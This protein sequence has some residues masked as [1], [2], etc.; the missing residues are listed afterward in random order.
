MDNLKFAC[1]VN[2]SKSTDTGETTDEHTLTVY[3]YNRL[4]IKYAMCITDCNK[5]QYPKVFLLP[6][7]CIDV[8]IEQVKT[9]ILQY[10]Y[11]K[12]LDVVNVTLDVYGSCSI[13]LTLSK[14][15]S[16]TPG[17]EARVSRLEIALQSLIDYEIIEQHIY[18][19]WSTY[20]E[21]QNLPTYKYFTACDNIRSMYKE[22]PV[23]HLGQIDG[24]YYQLMNEKYD[25]DVNVN[26]LVKRQFDYRWHH[27]NT[28]KCNT[29]DQF[30]NTVAQYRSYFNYV[31]ICE[32]EYNYLTKD[33]KYYER[34][35]ADNPKTDLI[36]FSNSLKVKSYKFK[37]QEPVIAYIVKYV[38]GWFLTNQALCFARK[39]KLDIVIN[40]N[41][42]TINI[43]RSKE[44]QMPYIEYAKTYMQTHVMLPVI[45][46]IKYDKY[47]IKYL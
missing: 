30:Q 18:P 43:L 40:N 27:Q 15:L 41:T 16:S 35:E 9:K 36:R 46:S 31:S 26:E 28:S 19:S 1:E 17:T 5:I 6:S 14:D 45:N 25:F 7:A 4:D 23:S 13:K 34:Y 33:V 8:I 22:V 24:V 39:M 3:T 32:K 38:F 12:Q 44:L 29:I 10:T 37:I 47:L 21:F 20:E 42:L 2:D 11:D